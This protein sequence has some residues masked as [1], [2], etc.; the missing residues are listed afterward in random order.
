SNRR[1]PT[2]REGIRQ[3]GRQ[4]RARAGRRSELRRTWKRGRRLRARLDPPKESRG[5][6]PAKRGLFGGSPEADA[7]RQLGGQS[8]HSRDPPLVRGT[9]PL[10]WLRSRE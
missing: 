7:Y 10:V 9:L 8:R 4:P 1:R 2:V 3:E 6:L 5:S